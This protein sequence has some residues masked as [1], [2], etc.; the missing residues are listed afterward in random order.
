MNIGLLKPQVDPNGCPPVNGFPRTSPPLG[1]SPYSVRETR[2]SQRVSGW[3]KS[4]S[5][6]R[7]PLG[8]IFRQAGVYK[9]EFSLLRARLRRV[10]SWPLVSDADA[11][12]STSLFQSGGFMRLAHL[13]LMEYLHYHATWI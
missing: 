1:E 2:V 12:G 5:N 10:N 8:A 11:K 6:G 9:S 7:P 4:L 3:D 13:H